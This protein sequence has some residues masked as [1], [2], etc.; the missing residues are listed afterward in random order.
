MPN[1]AYNL[2]F[3]FYVPGFLLHVGV[4]LSIGLF[5]AWSLATQSVVHGPTVS[6]PPRSS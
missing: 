3:S 6:A 4:L 1:D 2:S 5:S